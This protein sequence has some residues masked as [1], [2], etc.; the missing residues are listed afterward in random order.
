[1]H[2]TLTEGEKDRESK[3]K[4]EKISAV[5]FVGHRGGGK[6]GDQGERREAFFL[7][8]LSSSAEKRKKQIRKKKKKGKKNPLIRLR[9]GGGKG[10]SHTRRGP[11]AGCSVWRQGKGRK[12]WRGKKALGGSLDF[13]FCRPV[14]IAALQNGRKKKKKK[15]KKKKERWSHYSACEEKVGV[16]ISI[17]SPGGKERETMERELI[18]HTKNFFWRT[19]GKRKRGGGWKR[20]GKS[21]QAGGRCGWL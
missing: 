7:R 15:K 13:F 10:G 19:K 5:N 12:L 11:V 20:G 4:K 17:H 8:C 2:V 16:K 1:M 14:P 21:G 6:E 3:E 9:G 18:T